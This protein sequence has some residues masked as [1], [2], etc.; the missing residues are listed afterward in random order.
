MFR[1]WAVLFSNL[2]LEVT[3]FGREGHSIA[4]TTTAVQIK[5]H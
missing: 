3:E 4:T 1:I 2:E 5:R